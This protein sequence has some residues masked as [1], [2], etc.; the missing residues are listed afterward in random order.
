MFPIPEP[1][2]FCSLAVWDK[3]LYCIGGMIRTVEDKKVPTDNVWIVDTHDKVWKKGLSLPEPRM[4]G[5]AI[6][7]GN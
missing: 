6:T 1:C 5:V 7:H 2:C 4:D 3:K